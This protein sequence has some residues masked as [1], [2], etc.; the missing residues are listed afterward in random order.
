MRRPR[1]RRSGR[2]ERSRGGA[3]LPFCGPLRKA[4]RQHV[5]LEGHPGGQVCRG[6]G[7]GA[8]RGVAQPSNP[9]AL[10]NPNS[11]TLTLTELTLTHP[12]KL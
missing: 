10:H 9:L 4:V 12:K 7:R 5:R 11:I 3:A 2:G 1:Q 6:P 8:L